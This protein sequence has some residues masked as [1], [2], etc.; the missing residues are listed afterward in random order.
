MLSGR[1]LA[2]VAAS[3]ICAAPEA[4]AQQ[5]GEDAVDKVFT[6]GSRGSGP[7]R[8]PMAAVFW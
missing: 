5:S 3:L 7:I 4:L 6:P 8:P 2:W 1:C